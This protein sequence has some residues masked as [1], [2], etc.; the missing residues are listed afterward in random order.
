[1]ARCTS[2]ALG[3]SCSIFGFACPSS[4]VLASLPGSVITGAAEG[5][6]DF[7]SGTLAILVAGGEA[8]A[9]ASTGSTR[10]GGAVSDFTSSLSFFSITMA[11]FG[12]VPPR[13][14]ISGSLIDT[15]GKASVGMPFP[16]PR[17]IPLLTFRHTHSSAAVISFECMLQRHSICP[18]CSRA[19]ST[20]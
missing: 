8:G 2:T 19:S 4:L 12:L 7:F 5:K 13:R 11:S 20:V 9:D 6:D 1:V 3:I 10:A 15:L 18:V 17:L 14:S 16:S